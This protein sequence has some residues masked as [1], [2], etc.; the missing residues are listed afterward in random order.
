MMA[1]FYMWPQS[2]AAGHEKTIRQQ[3]SRADDIS[4]DRNSQGRRR[5]HE[6]D[7]TET[8]GRTIEIEKGGAEAVE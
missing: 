2:H 5:S 6:I 1:T 4:S 8:R 3:L 7:Q